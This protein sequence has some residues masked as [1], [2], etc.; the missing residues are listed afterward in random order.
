MNKPTKIWSGTVLP[1]WIDY[2][3]HMGDFAYGIAFTKAADNMMELIGVDELYR[4][5]RGCT[6]FTLETH[7]SFLKEIHRGKRI[8]IFCQVLDYD[9]SKIHALLSMT[10]GDEVPCAFYEVLLMHMR[11]QGPDSRP[12]AEP[13]TK[14]SYE[15]LEDLARRHRGLHRPERASASVGIR[16]KPG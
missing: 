13:F 1:E 3:G 11:V 5:D 14:D 6:M 16:R 15:A 8:E 2:N 4:T 10:T 12:V 9:R 7:I